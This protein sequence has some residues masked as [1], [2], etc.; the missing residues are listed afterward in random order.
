MP[1]YEAVFDGE[2]WYIEKDG[3]T[4]VLE[5]SDGLGLR[6]EFEHEAD[7]KRYIALVRRMI[8]EEGMQP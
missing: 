5:Q 3:V 1:N 8:E 6:V 2:V 7:A 4:L